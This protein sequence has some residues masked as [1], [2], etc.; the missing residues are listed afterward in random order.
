MAIKQWNGQTGLF[1][2][3]AEWSP[4]GVPGAGDTV[5]LSGSLAYVVT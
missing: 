1:A 2:T 3:S 4:S 5:D